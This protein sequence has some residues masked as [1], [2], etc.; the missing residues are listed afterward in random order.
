MNARGKIAVLTFFFALCGTAAI[1]TAYFQTVAD[2]NVRPGDLYAIV[3]RQLGELRAGNFSGAYEYASQGIQQRF[4]LAQF[5][6][7]VQ[8]DYAGLM[9]VGRA[10]YGEMQHV[11]RH[12]T[13]QVFLIGS[14]G[15]VIPCI[16]IMVR[17]G[18][19]W[20]IDGARMLP[21]WPP[22]TRSEGTML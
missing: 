1:V 20:R 14:D 2:A 8:T 19:S 17:E 3:D 12:A 4:S 18:D 9:R 13:I 22:N 15:E 16:Y 5:T 6:T 7:M 10:D 11:G 21:P